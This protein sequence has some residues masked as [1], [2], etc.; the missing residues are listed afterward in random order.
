LTRYKPRGK[1]VYL[2]KWAKGVT[3]TI[4]WAPSKVK[5]FL[6][7]RNAQLQSTLE[8]PI[9]QQESLITLADEETNY[10]VCV[11]PNCEAY[12]ELLNFPKRGGR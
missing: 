5:R 9:C 3:F 1:T 11:N 2:T 4:D 8:C 10:E 12:G 6:K 7:R